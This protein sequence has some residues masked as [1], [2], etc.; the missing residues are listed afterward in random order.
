MA[1]DQLV[2]GGTIPSLRELDQL[3]VK[4]LP[5]VHDFLRA[6]APPSWGPMAR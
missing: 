1:S 5:M 3:R 6:A 4:S 2:E